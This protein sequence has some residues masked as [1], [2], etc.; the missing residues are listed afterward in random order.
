[1]ELPQ[2]AELFFDTFHGQRLDSENTVNKIHRSFLISSA[3]LS[4]K[5][6]QIEFRRGLEKNQISKETE[7]QQ[8]NLVIEGIGLKK[9]LSLR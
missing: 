5:V 8:K 1:M 4:V 6:N 3:K 2:K 7:I 9:C